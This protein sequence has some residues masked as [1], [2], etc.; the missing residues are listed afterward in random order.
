MSSVLKNLPD[1][2]EWLSKDIQ[3]KFNN[4]SWKNSIMQ[5]HDPK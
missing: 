4:I 5:L 1:L 2:D 3:N